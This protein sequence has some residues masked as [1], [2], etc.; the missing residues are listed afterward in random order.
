MNDIKISLDHMTYNSKPDKWE[1]DEIYSRIGGKVKYLNQKYIGSYIEAIGQNGQ[2]FCP[3]TFIN[4]KNKKENF[5]QI[6][7]FILDFNNDDTNKLIS[8]EQVK[9]RSID[10][11][12]P[13]LFAYDTFSSTKS[14]KKFRV[15]F[16]NDAIVN[17]A[18]VA[19]IILEALLTI[20]PEANQKS[21]NISQMYYGGKKLIYLDK[22]IP[23]INIDSLISN[24]SL[25]W[26]NRY[27]KFHYK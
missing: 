23:M 1:T 17:Y 21:K 22:S 5:E 24:M 11:N 10:Y 15:G 26:Y 3:A 27:G 8:W 7:L 12:L 9:K 6:Q 2:T 20:F 4:G 18:K 13:L 16:L 14:N 25:Y 19:E